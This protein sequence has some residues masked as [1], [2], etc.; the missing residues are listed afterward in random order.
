MKLWKKMEWWFHDREYHCHTDFQLDSGM[1]FEIKVDGQIILGRIVPKD[2]HWKV[3]LGG[4]FQ[5]YK[6]GKGAKQ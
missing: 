2:E 4:S 1:K 6:N 5:P 3:H